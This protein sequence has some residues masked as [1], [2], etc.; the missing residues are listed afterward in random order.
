MPF[1][2]GQSGNPGG[3]PKKAEWIKGKGEE[4]LKMA[5]QLAKDETQKTTDRIS[6][7]RLVIEYDLGKPAAQVNLDGN[8]NVPII[9]DGADELAD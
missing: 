6:C 1:V 5:Y 9:I 8:L 2:K 3:R 4:C 7:L